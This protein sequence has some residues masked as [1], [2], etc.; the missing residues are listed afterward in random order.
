MSYFDLLTTLKSNM[1][2]LNALG[3]KVVVFDG[4]VLQIRN[5][6]NQVSLGVARVWYNLSGK[7]LAI[8]VTFQETPAPYEPFVFGKIVT[9]PKG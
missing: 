7:V 5:L 6:S 4:K 8:D 1:D 3:N 2:I 9:L